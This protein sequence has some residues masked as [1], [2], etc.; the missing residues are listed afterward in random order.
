MEISKNI[1][2]WLLEADPAIRWQ[3]LRDLSDAN[4][5]LI[6]IERTKVA[7]Q[8][9]GAKILA[10]QE[11][12]G[13]F[14]GGIYNP[15]W[16]ST[17]Y[18]I[19]LLRRLGLDPYHPQMPISCKLLLDK[20][21]YADGGINYFPSY[22][23]SETCVTGMVLSI[24]C[25]FQIQD[26]R[27]THLVDYLLREQLPDG[28]WNCRRFKGD[29][30]G[31]FHT[32]ISVL[33]GL[34]EFQKNNAYVSHK[35]TRSRDK[36]IEFLLIHRLFKSHRTGKIIDPKM[37]RLSFPPRWRYDILRVLDHFQ[38]TNIPYDSRMEDAMEII[39]KK[40]RSDG[41]WLLQNQHP[42]KVF[43][44]ME[45]VGKPSRWNTLRALRVLKFYR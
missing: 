8:G 23:N 3:T 27:M 1:L 45:K 28:G 36:A 20:G 19:L 2:K 7:Q 39:R 10:I 11:P 18:T 22:G 44:D 15:K 34:H 12:S 29:R 5:K 35:I 25:Y 31:S 17:T 38:A 33:E 30:H 16:I 6:K 26:Q 24:L 9:W 32:T 21:Y 14:G 43:F 42:G 41:R 37:T 4:Q 40:Q 13:Q